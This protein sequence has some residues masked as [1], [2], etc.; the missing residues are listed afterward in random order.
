MLSRSSAY[1]PPLLY[2]LVSHSLLYLLSCRLHFNE[3]DIHLS[4]LPLAHVFEFIMQVGNIGAGASIGFHRGPAKCMLL[5]LKSLRP[6]IFPSVPRVYNRIY[7][8]IRAKI[9]LL[10][11]KKQNLMNKA[12]AVK[13]AYLAHG[14]CTSKFWDKLVFRKFGALVGLDR[15]RVLVTGSAPITADVMDFLRIVFCCPVVE[16]Y[17][18]TE[19]AAAATC[20]YPDDFSV[21]H[22]GG[23]IPCNEVK[24]VDC[25][26]LGWTHWDMASE[27]ADGSG[28]LT[29]EH[30]DKTPADF[31][32]AEDYVA[33]VREWQAQ[34]AAA[35]CFNY[36]RGELC[37]RGANIF[38]GYYKNPEKTADALKGDG[39]LHSGDT[40]AI[41]AHKGNRI[42]IVGRSKEQF[43]LSQGEYIVPT[44][45]EN[46]Y[47]KNDL[48]ETAFVHGDGTQSNVVGIFCPSLALEPSPFKTWATAKGFTGTDEELCTNEALRT[49]LKAELGGTDAVRGLSSLEKVADFFLEHRVWAPAEDPEGVI[50]TATFKLQRKKAQERYAPQ[51]EAMYAGINAKGGAAVAKA[52]PAAAAGGTA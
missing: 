20:T 14:R 24:V 11:P 15:A 10:P 2:L 52:A 9:S 42:K 27:A 45:C 13:K 29:I 38:P 6:T 44:R 48:I 37:Y 12:F 22:I 25:P 39:W 30:P 32:S 49:A 17:G 41:E 19:N 46:A 50:I 43:K 51:I 31:G 36:P 4:Y 1:S 28:A 40:C 34:K 26:E 23:P 7:D 35:G 8:S 47:T 5:D 21:G 16:G 18:Q 3:T 33:H